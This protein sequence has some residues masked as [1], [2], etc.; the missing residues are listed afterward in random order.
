MLKRPRRPCA[1]LMFHVHIHPS[2]LTGV[3]MLYSVDTLALSPAG[4]SVVILSPRR[5][6]DI[7]NLG[8]GPEESQRRKSS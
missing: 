3:T 8:C 2:P 1:M 4:G 6:I 5:R 7:G